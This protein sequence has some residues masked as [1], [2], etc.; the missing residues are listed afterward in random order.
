MREVY[1][2]HTLLQRFLIG[3]YT[4]FNK[5]AFF[6][7]YAVKK[8]TLSLYFMY[9]RWYEDAFSRLLAN[10]P[11]LFTGG[12]ILDI[13]ACIGYTSILFSK[14]LS[15]GF[16]V[17]AFEP[18]ESNIFW[19]NKMVRRFQASDRI[20]PIH[21]AVGATQGTVAFWHNDEHFGDHRVATPMFQNTG[22]EARHI[23]SVP[24]LSVDNFVQSE[25]AGSAITL[26]KID[27]QGYELPVCQGM[28]QTLL[29]N[30]DVI[31]VVEYSPE[32]MVDLGFEPSMLL[33]WFQQ[34]DY[35]LYLLDRKGEVKIADDISI[36]RLVKKQGYVDLMCSRKP[37]FLQPHDHSGNH[38]KM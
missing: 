16:N 25:L 27:V 31:V 8:L 35:A 21:A 26:I 36:E 22:L 1:R 9:K 33:E 11:D 37:R 2:S 29:A 10:Y 30:P 4:R 3:L 32:Y 28:E 5:T 13:G 14:G 15:P 18:D 38:I 20:V 34:K 7:R 23:F 17:Y 12:H 19:L 6:H 24:Q